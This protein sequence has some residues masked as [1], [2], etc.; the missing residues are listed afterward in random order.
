[1]FIFTFPEVPFTT[2]AQ[3]SIRLKNGKWVDASTKFCGCTR[4]IVSYKQENTY[5]KS[6]D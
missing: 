2:A 3:L 1:M 5:C 4:H 6:Q